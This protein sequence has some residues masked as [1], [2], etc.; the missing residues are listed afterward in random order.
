MQMCDS[1]YK[2]ED[3]TYLGMRVFYCTKTSSQLSAEHIIRSS[4][5]EA[6]SPPILSMHS[7]GSGSAGRAYLSSVFFKK[8]PAN[9]I[10]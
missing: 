4:S 9:E 6:E 3:D 5:F 10:C 1:F 2:G 7:E 8:N